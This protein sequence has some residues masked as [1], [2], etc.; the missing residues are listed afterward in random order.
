MDAIFDD[1]TPCLEAMEVE[2]VLGDADGA[3]DEVLE[4]YGSDVRC[5]VEF[6]AAQGFERGPLSCAVGGLRPME[7]LFCTQHI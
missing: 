2:L 1:D 6:L 5:L 7:K 3:S 4:G